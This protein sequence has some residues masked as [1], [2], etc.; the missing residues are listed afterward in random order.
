M[1]I[2]IFF[3][4]VNGVR[5][6][7]SHDFAITF[8]PQLTLDKNKNY[9]LAV[10]SVNMSTYI[11]YSHDIGT[12]QATVILLNGNFSYGDISGFV[13]QSLESNKHLKA[14]IEVKMVPSS[15]RVLRTLETNYKVDLQTGEFADR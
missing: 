15:V 3:N 6:F 1:N 7:K 5:N 12:T 4:S 13:Q 10:D 9:Y 8:T 14:G 11:E 2:P